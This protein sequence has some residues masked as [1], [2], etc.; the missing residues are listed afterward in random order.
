MKFSTLKLSSQEIRLLAGLASDQLFRREF[1]DPRMPGNRANPDEIALGKLLVGRLESMI[2][3]AAG[4]G[5]ASRH[6]VTAR[7]WHSRPKPRGGTPDA[8]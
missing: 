6:A 1:I 7:H 5:Q 3:E 8:I 2:E 4:D